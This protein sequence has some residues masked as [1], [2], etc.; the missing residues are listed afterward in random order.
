MTC[1]KFKTCINQDQKASITQIY[2]AIIELEDHLLVEGEE[3]P[4][5]GVLAPVQQRRHVLFRD[6]GSQGGS[7]V[8][9][10]DHLLMN[11]KEQ[12]SEHVQQEGKEREKNKVQ[13]KRGKK[14]L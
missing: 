5:V 14:S 7:H 9:H 3:R 2:I 1:L 13:R 4:G 8:K 11:N 10:I 12:S 6:R